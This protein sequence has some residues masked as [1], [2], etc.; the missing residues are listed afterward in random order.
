MQGYRIEGFFVQNK[1][2]FIHNYF[3]TYFII[4]DHIQMTNLSR[5]RP[6]RNFR[7]AFE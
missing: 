1:T 7:H 4:I 2:P 5:L 6:R 3:F